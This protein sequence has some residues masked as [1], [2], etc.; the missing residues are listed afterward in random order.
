MGNGTEV[1]EAPKLF[2]GRGEVLVDMVV[3]AKVDLG[4]IGFGSS[5]AIVLDVAG[6]GR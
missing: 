1:F 2:V 6:R 3:V 4:V 5:D